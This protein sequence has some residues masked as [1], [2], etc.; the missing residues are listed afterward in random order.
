MKR[1]FFFCLVVLGCLLGQSRVMGQ[2]TPALLITEVYYDTPGDD[3]VEEWIEV[4][5]VGTAVLDI[6]DYK[7]GDEETASDNEGMRRFPEATTLQPGQVIIIAQTATGFEPLFGRLPDYEL[8]D[9]DP[10]VPDMRP[11]LSWATGDIALANGGDEIVLLNDDNR[12]VDVINFG[13]STSFFTPSIGDVLTN[14][15]IERVPAACDTDTAA[16]WQPQREPTPG[17]IFLEGECAT[18]QDSADFPIL[19]PIGEIQGE[20]DVSPFVNQIITFRGVVTGV[21]ADQNTL[22]IIYHTLF[23]QDVP[24]SED[25]NPATSDGIAVFTGQERPNLLPGDQIRI[26]GK[27]TE[28]F[29]FTEVEDDGLQIEVEGRGV[30]LPQPAPVN[31]PADNTTQPLYFEPFESM[32]V[33]LDS[34]TWVVGSTF[35]GCSF[36]VVRQDSG[37]TRILRQSNADPIGQIMPILYTTDSDCTGFP[38]LKTGDS[39]ENIAGPLIYNFDQFKIV[40][41]NSSA[42]QIAPSPLA[43]LP[44]P[45][46]LMAGQFSIATYNVEN[47]FDT[48]DDTGDDTEPKL[49]P[50]QLSVKLTKL[51]YHITFNLGCPTI[52]G[53]EE[54]E[55]RPLLEQL[56]AQVAGTCHFTYEITH[57][58]SADG[59]GI[60]LALLTDPTHVQVMAAELHQ[61]CSPI[62][63]EAVDAAASCPAG[64]YPLFSRQPLAASLLVD[65]QPYT[66]IVNH[67]KSKRGGEDDTEPERLAQAAFMNT[68]VEGLLT[69]DPQARVLVTGD[70]NDYELSP[71]LLVMTSGNGRLFNALSLIPQPERYSYVFAGAAQLIDHILVS[72]AL[73]DEIVSA[74]IVHVNADYPDLWG[75]DISPEYLPYKSTDHDTPLLVLQGTD[76]TSPAPTATATPQ[77]TS[78]AT[79]GFS[80]WWIVAGVGVVGT[81]VVGF[82]F[83]RRR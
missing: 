5:N 32:L 82:V 46:A 53:I 31:P 63:T 23:V 13:E 41:Q 15:S 79:N 17:I 9:T 38:H 21:F 2:E 40:Q 39:V 4:A 81:A 33:T 59:R 16:D 47:L 67:F 68:L 22:G 30:P 37:Q 65:G 60:D 69:A 36:A 45:L 49:T 28:F 8:A 71:P 56:V 70:L 43:P 64:Q 61:T 48:I 20:G 66:V 78:E 35:S 50:E 24:G 7:I 62:Q 12:Y 76:S 34:P 77:P 44:S 83:L 14:Q 55:K 52:L 58:E 74:T 11:Y 51:S 73:V 19:P 54:V 26:T 29:G 6:S 72:P 25:G 80:W 3:Q 75:E 27:I 42:L 10:T 18:P 57:F 1:T